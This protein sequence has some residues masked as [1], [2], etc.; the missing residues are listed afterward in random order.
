MWGQA[1]GR[2][3]VKPGI[4]V[5]AFC[6]LSRP[7][8]SAEAGALLAGAPV[9]HALYQPVQAHFVALPR[10][11][12]PA[13]DP[14]AV[15]SGVIE[16]D[17]RVPVPHVIPQGIRPISTGRQGA[18]PR[19]GASSA[20]QELR[21]AVAAAGGRVVP[22]VR[23]AFAAAGERGSGRH[24]LVVSTSGYLIARR[25]PANRIPEFLTPLANEHFGDG[26]WGREVQAAV[27]HAEKRQ[28]QSLRRDFGVETR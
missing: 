18:S 27:A 8:S 15:R 9:D 24:D 6:L 19:P 2:A 23:S 21:D 5:R 4:R 22:G 12:P 28:A 26:D 16:G 10:F 17:E 7:L 3:G 14:I 11:I 20:L 1:T 13:R 25:W